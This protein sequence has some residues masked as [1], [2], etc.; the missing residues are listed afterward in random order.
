VREREGERVVDQRAVLLVLALAVT[1]TGCFPVMLPPLKGDVGYAAR[2]GGDTGY[3]FS[4]G[5]DVASLIPKPNF[6]LA[7][8]GGYVQTSTK[9]GESRTP[10]HGLYLEGGPRVAGG[11]WWRVFVGPR[12]ELYF[13]PRGPDPAYAGIVRTQ[14]EIF[15]P[16]LGET[17]KS[18]DSGSTTNTLS[19]RRVLPR[20]KPISS[21]GFFWGVAFG[22]AA[23]GLYVEGGYQKLPNDAG[24][25]LVGAGAVLRIPA[26]A[27]VA[28]C[29]WDFAPKHR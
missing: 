9:Y 24:Y 1:T 16:S 18:D 13:A 8:G 23:L 29:A 17:G 5:T 4:A 7:A 14:I 25:P 15:Q 21:P 10:I 26:I 11:E 19:T 27:G 6:P 22:M 12:F 3:R 20:P 2:L 28:C